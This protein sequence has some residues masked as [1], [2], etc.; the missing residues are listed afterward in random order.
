MSAEKL[1]QQP[2]QTA[3]AVDASSKNSFSDRVYLCD[4][5]CGACGCFFHSAQ[6]QLVPAVVQLR[7]DEPALPGSV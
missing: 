7:L 1:N 2:P 3:E 5:T 6:F 4:L